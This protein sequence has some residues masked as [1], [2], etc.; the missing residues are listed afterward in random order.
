MPARIAYFAPAG[1]GMGKTGVFRGCGTDGMQ[2]LSAF[3]FHSVGRK[4][5][6]CARNSVVRQQDGGFPGNLPS[7][8]RRRR[9]CFWTGKCPR[10]LFFFFFPDRF[11]GSPKKF[12]PLCGKKF[13]SFS[14]DGNFFQQRNRDFCGEMR[15]W[16]ISP[17]RFLTFRPLTLAFCTLC[18]LWNPRKMRHKGSFFSWIRIILLFP[19]GRIPFRER[20]FP[21]CGCGRKLC[22]MDFL[23]NLAS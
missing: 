21:P 2:V 1:K 12:P 6:A 16:S 7:R 18:V 15:V 3:P 10:G 4:K 9:R 19:N 17:G 5:A 22:G 14:K 23:F 20:D 13:V 8:F 11:R